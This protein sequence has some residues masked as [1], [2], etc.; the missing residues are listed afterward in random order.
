MLRLESSGDQEKI[1]DYQLTIFFMYLYLRLVLHSITHKILKSTSQIY[2]NMPDS[3]Q[4]DCA[5]MCVDGPCFLM[6]APVILYCVIVILHEQDL[7]AVRARSATYQLDRFIHVFKGIRVDRLLHH[8]LSCAWILFHLEWTT[9]PFLDYSFI[10]IAWSLDV[11]ARMWYWW[12]FVARLTRRHARK[13]TVWKLHSGQGADYIIIP[14]SPQ[15]MAFY[16]KLVFLYFCLNWITAVTLEAIYLNR[17]KDETHLLWKVILYPLPAVF[18]VLDK[19][20]VVNFSKYAKESYWTFLLK[21][22]PPG[23]KEKE[24]TTTSHDSTDDDSTSRTSTADLAFNSTSRA[25]RMDDIL[26]EPSGF[27]TEKCG[28]SDNV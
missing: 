3:L 18:L 11:F 19:A 27:M 9:E 23:E 25:I 1:L 5:F 13:S 17:Y 10:L 8:F 28:P 12:C 15:R 21:S 16:G 26:E 14:S 6:W 4:S 7:Q 24:A 22:D 20:F 2:A